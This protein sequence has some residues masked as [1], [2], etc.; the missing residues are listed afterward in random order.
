MSEKSSQLRIIGV[1]GVTF[2]IAGM[3]FLVVGISSNAFWITITGSLGINLMTLGL[4]LIFCVF[5]KPRVVDEE[6]SFEPSRLRVEKVLGALL[7]PIGV[8]FLISSM[9]FLLY[10][11]IFLWLCF[12]RLLGIPLLLT[13]LAALVTAYFVPMIARIEARQSIKKPVTYYR[14]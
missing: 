2:L 3:I 10:S 12:S 8:S 13:G 4:G 9:F 5:S 7:L 11:S 14:L 1:L 6:L